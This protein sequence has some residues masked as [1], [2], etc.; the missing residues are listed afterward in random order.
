M[1]R[2]V[3]TRPLI[4]GVLITALAVIISACGS[5]SGSSDSTTADTSEGGGAISVAAD[6]ALQPYQF[7]AEGTKDWEGINVDVAGALSKQLGRELKFTPATF[8]TIIPGLQ[9]GRYDAALTGHLDTVEREEVVD[10]VDYMKVK[11]NF[12]LLASN[13]KTIESYADLCG[14]TVAVGKGSFDEELGIEQSEKCKEEGKD[15]IDL[16]V[17]PDLTSEMLALESGHVEVMPNDSAMNA[18]LMKNRGEDT[19]KTTGS[20][21]ANGL[22][23]MALPK[24][25][26]N[27][28]P[29]YKAFQTIFDNGELEAIYDKWGIADRMPAK[30]T[31]NDGVE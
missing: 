9:A 30:I 27:L 19:F 21:E 14:V 13:P 18:Y 4:L 11:N 3:R 16:K 29:I 8:D 5:S 20:Y 2:K 24:G 23:G 6:P 25:S 15:P 1:T 28:K 12:L 17:F 26:E 7:Y 10:F 22:M 31:M